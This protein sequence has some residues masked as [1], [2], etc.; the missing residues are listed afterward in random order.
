MLKWLTKKLESRGERR[1]PGSN[2]DASAP[3][4]IDS[5]EWRKRGNA[6]LNDE[7]LLEAEQCYRSGMQVNPGDPICY[8]NLGYV[9]LEQRRL[10]EAEDMLTKAVDLNPADSD[11]HYLLANLKRD[12]GEWRE[13]V[14][15]YRRALTIKPDFS[16]CRRDLCIALAQTGELQEAQ[17]VMNQ[18]PAFGSDTLNYHF[19]SGLLNIETGNFVAAI[20]CFSLAAQ[21]KPKDAVILLNLSTAQIAVG[22]YFTGLRTTQ[23]VLAFAPDNAQ[24]YA[25][26]AAAYRMTGQRELAIE[27]YRNSLRI[28]SQNLYVHQNLLFDL[29]DFPGCPPADYLAEAKRYGRKIAARAKPF[30]SWLCQDPRH[31]QRPLRVGFL[32]ADL[33]HHPVGMFL[34]NVLSAL[35]PARVTSIAYS[36]R[37]A[38]DDFFSERLK[39]LF[40]EWNRVSPMADQE[41]AEKIH[42]DCIDILVDLSGHS[43]QTRLP[44]FAWRSAPVQV[45]WLGYWA[46]TGVAEI[47]YILVDKVGVRDNEAQFY[48][49]TPW[50]LP[51]TR[52]CFT[53]PPTR[54]PIAVGDLPAL[55]KGHVT[56]GTYQQPNKISHA[57]LVLWSQVLA[58]L[59]TARLRLH[60]L[61][62][63]REAIVSDIKRRLMEANIDLTRVDFLGKALYEPY[64]ES[65]A[66]VDMVLDTHP[67]PGGTTTAE[68]LWM[69]VPTL[70]LT[71]NT[72]LARQGEGIL[73]CVGLGDWVATNEQDY[74][75]KAVEKVS[76]LSSLAVLRANL[77]T[78]ALASPLFEC[79]RFARHL[80]DAF[81][82]M[83]KAEK[84]RAQWLA[85]EVKGVQ[86]A[87]G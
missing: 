8:A 77:R 51:D 79:V 54:W 61:R 85:I 37:H 6:F 23:E 70:T 16:L 87:V 33:C 66:E 1:H 15:C 9:L 12:C 24:A 17:A 56:F 29:A 45:A 14:I 84:H 32:S 48:S 3:E 26:L 83:A 60:G 78:R 69:G 31:R 53:P 80:E 27:N 62:L 82:G 47:D 75:K 68:A 59:P 20:A 40:S 42:A 63:E 44:V 65:Y 58:E 5:A 43:G 86:A 57:T 30:S 36:S 11:S 46:S 28:N 7:K 67:Y 73:L 50:F 35:D 74:V 38:A 41:L 55:R 49:E 2:S 25:N 21:L 34:A 13:A 71:G 22:D 10:A 39:K 52:L 72:L 76:D 64:L 18:G 81:E 19:F 4:S